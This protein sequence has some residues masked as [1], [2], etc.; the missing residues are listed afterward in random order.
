MIPAN[1]VISYK[2]DGH[3]IVNTGHT[4]QINYQ[5]SSKLGVNG[6]SYELRQFHFHSPSKNYFRNKSYPMEMHLVHADTESNLAVVPVMFEEDKKSLF[7]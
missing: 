2:L 3:K 5:S 4:I 7:R 1:I 6:H